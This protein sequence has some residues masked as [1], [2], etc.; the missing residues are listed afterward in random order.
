MR[1][2]SVIGQELSVGI[3]IGGTFT[4][5]VLYDQQNKALQWV[6]VPSTPHDPEQGLLDAVESFVGIKFN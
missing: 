4:D 1:R 5:A 6:K 2:D 3:D